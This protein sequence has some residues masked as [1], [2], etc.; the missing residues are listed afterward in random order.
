MLIPGPRRQPGP[1]PVLAYGSCCFLARRSRA[2]PLPLFFP[3]F[4]GGVGGAAAPPY[5]LEIESSSSSC[6][7]KCGKLRGLP[8]SFPSAC[9]K[10]APG[11]SGQATFPQARH[12]PQPGGSSKKCLG[13]FFEGLGETGPPDTCCRFSPDPYFPPTCA[14]AGHP[15]PGPKAQAT[16]PWPEVSSVGFDDSGLTGR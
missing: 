6:C 7:G 16:Q 1:R 15:V 13:H 3:G 5:V 8:S 4:G 11:V 9:G 14:C 10:V 12:F 2:R